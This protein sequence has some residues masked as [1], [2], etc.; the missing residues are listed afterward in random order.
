MMSSAARA[1]GS[2]ARYDGQSVG[3]RNEA[4]RRRIL[5]SN[6]P[7]RARNLLLL[8]AGHC[9]YGDNPRGCFAHLSTLAGELGT[10]QYR[11]TYRELS[12][13]Q[14]GTLLALLE[15]GGWIDVHRHSRTGSKFARR[16]IQLGRTCWVIPTTDAPRS[17]ANDA[18]RSSANVHLETFRRPPATLP[19]GDQKHEKTT[20]TEPGASLSFPGSA[21]KGPER[22][23]QGFD[24]PALVAALV[25][26]LV[27]LK[28]AAAK[29]LTAAMTAAQAERWIRDAS[30]GATEGL[31]RIAWAI[32]GAI[33][34]PG[35][36]LGPV[37][38]VWWLNGTL[39]HWRAGDGEPPDG[40]PPFLDP[41][42]VD[43]PPPLKIAAADD[44]ADEAR[45][46]EALA[47]LKALVPRRLRT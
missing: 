32:H 26:A 10:H 8:I 11:G 44:P 35:D 2:E 33:H 17:S 19:T 27:G 1:T 42:R 9:H 34:R 4:V 29:G 15:Q 47:M 7:A 22:L 41:P 45:N 40:W 43:P 36:K 5:G 12:L 13:R 24:L 23:P 30:R 38:C 14:V 39:R 25:A 16:T 31:R 28:V 37:K 20:T 18:P 21:E 46:A 6:L 3:R